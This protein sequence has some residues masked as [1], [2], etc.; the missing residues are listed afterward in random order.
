MK[1]AGKQLNA[2]RP[3]QINYFLIS[4]FR[5]IGEQAIILQQQALIVYTYITIQVQIP[6]EKN[7]YPSSTSQDRKF[8]PE[9]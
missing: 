7:W 2:F 8:I 9:R 3:N 1:K 4:L 5:Y 6:D